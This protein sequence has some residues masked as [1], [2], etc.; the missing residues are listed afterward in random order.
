MPFLQAFHHGE[1]DLQRINRAVIILIPKTEASTSPAAFRSVLLQN[2]PVKILTKILTSRLQ[3]QIAKLVDI[4][5][6]GFIKGRS[7]AENFVLATELV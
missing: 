2:C 5:Q 3:L 7:I 1:A 6:T 4:D